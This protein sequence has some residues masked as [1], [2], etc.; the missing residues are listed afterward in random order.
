MHF[1][2]VCIVFLSC[3]FKIG[4]EADNAFYPCTLSVAENDPFNMGVPHFEVKF[5]VLGLPV[6][7][8]KMYFQIPE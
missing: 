5:H 3:M 8:Y 6:L 7:S 2:V 1:L 4:T